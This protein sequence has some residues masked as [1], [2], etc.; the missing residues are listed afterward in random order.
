MDDLRNIAL[1]FSKDYEWF[2]KPYQKLERVFH[3]VFKHLDVG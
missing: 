2:E 3:Q 1:N